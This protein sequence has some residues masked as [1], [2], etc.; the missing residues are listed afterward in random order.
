MTISTETTYVTSFPKR[1]NITGAPNQVFKF[2]NYLDYL[3]GGVRAK[4]IAAIGI[5]NPGS[6]C[7]QYL[8]TPQIH[9]N[10]S[11]APIAFVGN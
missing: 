1:N 2:D 10:L 9:Y 5:I 3:T 4:T 8:F 11:G 6:L 7:L